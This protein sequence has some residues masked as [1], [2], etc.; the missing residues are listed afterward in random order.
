MT[1]LKGSVPF[2]STAL[3]SVALLAP[4]ADAAAAYEMESY[5]DWPGGSEIAARDYESAVRSASAGAASMSSTTALVAA[6]NLC[7]A[8]TVQGELAPAAAACDRALELAKSEDNVHGK[9][10]GRHLATAKALTNR[11][12]LRAVGGDR[13]R[14]AADFRKAAALQGTGTAPERNLAYLES[15]P[16]D[17]VAATA[18]E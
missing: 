2:W 16:A 9:R 3:C 15:R 8:Y 14:A 13:E 17:R 18:A 7:V 12:V 11:G 5:S 4:V 10:L 6:T 1:N